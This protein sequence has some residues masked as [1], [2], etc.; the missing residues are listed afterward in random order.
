MHK[1]L[2]KAFDKVN[3]RLLVKSLAQKRGLQISVDVDFG[4]TSQIENNTLP[5]SFLFDTYTGVPQGS[6]LGPLFV[7]S[8]PN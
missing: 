7:K 8:F 3:D 6:Y 2:S 4:Q 1:D 5:Y